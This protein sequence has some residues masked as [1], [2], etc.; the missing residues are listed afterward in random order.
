[1]KN[2]TLKEKL[3]TIVGFL[4]VGGLPALLTIGLY[5]LH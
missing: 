2:F 3:E 1:M 4:I 5:L